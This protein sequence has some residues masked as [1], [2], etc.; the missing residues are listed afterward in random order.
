M[1]AVANTPARNATVVCM[2]LMIAEMP[3]A[4]HEFEGLRAARLHQAAPYVFTCLA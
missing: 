2:M 3:R 1:G 4:L